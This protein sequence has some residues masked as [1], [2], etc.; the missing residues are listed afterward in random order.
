MRFTA[1]LEYIKGQCAA[2]VTLYDHGEWSG[3]GRV[4]A[5]S[6]RRSDLY[7][8]GYRDAC[9]RA[10]GKGGDLDRFS[11]HEEPA[12]APPLRVTFGEFRQGCASL[13]VEGVGGTAEYGEL[14][15]V[16]TPAA[17][18]FSRPPNELGSVRWIASGGSYLALGT[19]CPE[20]CP[21]L[22]K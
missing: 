21:R 16:G 9:Q 22:T 2:I 5:R 13:Q 8:I 7:E 18:C 10:H 17:R 6:G 3:G 1:T 12:P 4:E 14:H 11:V 20:G 19:C 15:E